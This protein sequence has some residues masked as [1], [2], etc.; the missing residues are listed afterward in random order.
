MPFAD[1]ER[2]RQYNHDYYMTR[3]LSYQQYLADFCGGGVICCVHVDDEG[4]RCEETEN[5]QFSHNVGTEKL[6][7]ISEAIMSGTTLEEI[8]SEPE[9]CSLRCFN[10]HHI[11]D[12]RSVVPV[13]G[14]ITCFCNYACR[15]DA[16]VKAWHVYVNNYERN[17]RATDPV[18]RARRNK[19]KREDARN[20]R[21]TDP[22]WAEAERARSFE[23]YH[24]KIMDR[25]LAQGFA[26]DGTPFPPP[27][28]EGVTKTLEWHTPIH[29][30]LWTRV[31]A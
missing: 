16:C 26:P 9:K 29:T 12:G 1:P 19:R 13:H 17:R 2:K 3:K 27:I 14:T 4:I 20:R 5:L 11:Y 18:Y 22:V 15:C 31:D 8:H 23:R 7:E 25:L 28:P 30:E 24:R 6:F 21:A 10:H